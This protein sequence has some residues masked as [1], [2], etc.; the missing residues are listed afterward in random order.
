[1]EVA[2]VLQ[3][4]CKQVFKRVFQEN[5]KEVLRKIEE[6][7]EEAKRYFKDIGLSGGNNIWATISIFLSFSFFRPYP[8]IL[9]S[10]RIA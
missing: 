7:L 1:M 6:C 2:R 3:R 10:H 9:F 8:I 4:C 5:L